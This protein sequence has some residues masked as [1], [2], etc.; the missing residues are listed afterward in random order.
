MSKRK[1]VKAEAREPLRLVSPTAE[2]MAG[3]LFVEEDVVDRVHGRSLTIGK[4]FRRK[5]M[6]DLLAKQGMFS[7]REAKALRQYRHYAGLADKSLV[8]DSLNRRPGGGNHDGPTVEVLTAIQMTE[9]CE[10]ASGT[11]AD[12]LRAVIV[13]DMSLSQWAI[14]R[15]GSVEICR[16]RKGK[17]VCAIEPRR[18][19]LDAAKLEIRMAARRVESELAA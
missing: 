8:R 19:A 7:E 10:R 3:G 6:V 4:A 14:H 17:V 11:L 16:E 5:P 13:N 9:A 15:G 2:Q 12:I 18:K 1:R